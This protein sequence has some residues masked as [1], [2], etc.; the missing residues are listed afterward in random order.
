[1]SKISFDNYGKLAREVSDATLVSGRYAM[2]ADS[3]RSILLDVI[4][5]L[6]IE[7]R[8]LLLD[9]GCNVGNLLIPLS[10]LTKQATGIDHP[11]CLEG[12]KKRFGG[13]NL[14]LLPGD[15]LDMA[16]AGPFDKILCYSVL[17]YLSNKEEVFDFIAKALQ[18]LAPGG[19]ILLGDIPNRSRK[20]RFTNSQSGREFERLWQEAAHDRDDRAVAALELAPDPALVQ[21]DDELLLEICRRC[22]AEGFDAYVLRQ[23]SHLP[24]GNTRE[25]IL[26]IRPS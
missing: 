4:E 16:I 8:D 12:L 15:F 14:R 25:D 10:F 17:H 2:Q 3:E 6:Q 18:L 24:F 21:F 23:P 13:D 19:R 20:Q 26:V 5:K 7:P 11:S 22:R 9:I 1:M